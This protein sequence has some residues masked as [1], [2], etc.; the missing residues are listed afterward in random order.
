LI[1]TEGERRGRRAESAT[2]ARVRPP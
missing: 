1:V 2:A